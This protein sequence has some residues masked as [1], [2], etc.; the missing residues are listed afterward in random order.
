MKLKYIF[1]SI[2]T[3]TITHNATGMVRNPLR[4]NSMIDS[5]ETDSLV[6]QCTIDSIIS[7]HTAIKDAIDSSNHDIQ[8]LHRFEGALS[9]KFI[10]IK[11]TAL[12]EWEKTTLIASYMDLMSDIA[13]L[14]R[15]L[16]KK[17]L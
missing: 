6:S 9:Q 2:V 17:I 5:S 10:L 3:L 8:T 11:K 16:S 1:A 4:D 15:M 12:Q 7:T 13:K 14:K